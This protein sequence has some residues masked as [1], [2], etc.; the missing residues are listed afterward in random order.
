MAGRLD[1]QRVDDAAIRAV[2]RVPHNGGRV[3]RIWRG[4]DRLARAER[5]GGDAVGV[6]ADRNGEPARVTVERVG[7]EL[8]V[9]V[10]RDGEHA[11]ADR[12]AR[13]RLAVAHLIAAGGWSSRP[14]LI[15]EAE[16][17]M[18]GSVHQASILLE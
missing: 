6:G 14:G 13:E 3:Q 11:V 8:A 1:V 15:P 5:R 9:R 18:N 12:N 7:T 10:E 2:Q 17:Q 16:A 4:G